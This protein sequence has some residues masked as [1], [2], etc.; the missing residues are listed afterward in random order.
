MG[1]GVL[2][3]SA[4]ARGCASLVSVKALRSYHEQGLLIPDTIDPDTG[5]RSYRVSQLTDAAIIA[6]LLRPPAGS[7]ARRA[8]R[9]SR[10]RENRRGNASRADAD[11]DFPDLR[12]LPACA[13]PGVVEGS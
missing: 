12:D 9:S 1:E 7:A 11:S 8:V 5:Y 13:P 6:R 2:L 3:I 10:F 4:S